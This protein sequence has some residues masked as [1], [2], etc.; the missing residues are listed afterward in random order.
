MLARIS[1]FRL[2]LR[3][4][5]AAALL[6]PGFG[7]AGC[8]NMSDSLTSAF[9]DPAKFDLYDCKQLEVER[10]KLATRSAELQRLMAKAET[11]FAGPVVTELAY[12]NE[13]IAV[14]GQTQVADEVWRRNKC[15]ATG[16]ASAGPAPP[17][18]AKGEHPRMRSGGAVY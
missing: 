14:R 8:A 3:A 15:V 10:T 7:L 1:S 11:G 6:G 16:P 5:L 18:N 17:E 9:A 13:Y 2:L 12:R 4:A